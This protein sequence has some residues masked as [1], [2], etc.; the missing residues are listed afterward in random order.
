MAMFMVFAYVDIAWD[1]RP[2]VML[3]LCAAFCARLRTASGGCV[4]GD[5]TNSVSP[6]AVPRALAASGMR[7][8]LAAAGAVAAAG[9]GAVASSRSAASRC[10]GRR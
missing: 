4:H 10:L 7:R 2:A 3:A 9:V 1:I 6:A 8:T 5:Q